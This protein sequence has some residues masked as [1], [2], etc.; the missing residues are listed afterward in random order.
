MAGGGKKAKNDNTVVLGQ[1]AEP[2]DTHLSFVQDTAQKIVSVH[3]S[4]GYPFF[5]IDETI[6]KIHNFGRSLWTQMESKNQD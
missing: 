6:P 5:L 1:N 3:L 4:P 2:V